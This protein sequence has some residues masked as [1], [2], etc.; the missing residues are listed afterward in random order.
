MIIDHVETLTLDDESVRR[1]RNELNSLRYLA[2]GLD[3]LNRQV[4]QIEAEVRSRIPRDKVV[5]AIGNA[6]WLQNLP[7]GLVA[8]SFH[9]Y[10]VAA[11]NYVGLAGWLGLGEDADAARAY[12]ARVIP[13]TLLWRN[14]VAAHFSRVAPR[15]GDT[16]AD[17]VSSVM[18]PVG[19]VDDAFVAA[20]FN[21]SQSGSTSRDMRWSLTKTHAELT[22]RYWAVG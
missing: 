8:C 17:L 12:Q 11:C 10:A 3:F 15:K 4:Q 9:W 21:Y 5:F 14:K 7:L 19:F 1:C 22:K 16:P 6:P 2:Q 18:F 20:P 13:D